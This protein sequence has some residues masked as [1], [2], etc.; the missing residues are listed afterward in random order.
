MAGALSI[1]LSMVERK[2]ALWPHPI[3]MLY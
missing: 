2:S 3:I 1:I